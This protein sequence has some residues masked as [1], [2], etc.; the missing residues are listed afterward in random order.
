MGGIALWYTC[1]FLLLLFLSLK[2]L[3]LELQKIFLRKTTEK[4]GIDKHLKGRHSYHLSSKTICSA[5]LGDHTFV[6]N[7]QSPAVLA[8]LL[9]NLQRAMHGKKHDLLAFSQNETRNCLSCLNGLGSNFAQSLEVSIQ[10]TFGHSRAKSSQRIVTKLA[11]ATLVHLD[12]AAI[13][14]AIHSSSH[15]DERTKFCHSDTGKIPPLTLYCYNT[16]G[17]DTHHAIVEAHMNA[18]KNEAGLNT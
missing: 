16:N 2:P 6:L 12:W 4:Q 7:P 17:L 11:N 9:E 1:L 15:C 14:S 3:L 13:H 10:R 18:S 8:F 5:D